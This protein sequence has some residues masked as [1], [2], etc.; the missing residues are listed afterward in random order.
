[1]WRYAHALEPFGH[2]RVFILLR[3]LFEP[4]ECLRDFLHRD[5]ILDTDVVLLGGPGAE[6]PHDHADDGDRDHRYVITIATSRLQSVTGP[7]LRIM[8]TSRIPG[9][10]MSLRPVHDA[11][12]I[13]FRLS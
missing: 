8:W 6:V 12:E 1:M 9:G 11:R 3:S 7:I 10:P 2:L 5:R 13:V 4:L